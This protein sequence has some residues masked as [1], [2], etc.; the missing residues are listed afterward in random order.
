VNVGIVAPE[1]PPEI[2]GIQTY[3]YEFSV[4][5]ARRGINVTVFTSRANDISG[6]QQDLRIVPVL[7]CRRRIDAGVLA[8]Y[9]FD[10]WHS[11]NAAYSWLSG[12][13]DRVVLSVHGNDFLRPYLLMERPNLMRYP[14]FW[15][16]PALTRRVERT[17]GRFRTQRLVTRT[18]PRV[19]HIITNSMFT[20]E[21][22]LQKYPGCKG[23]TSPGMVGVGGRFLESRN[24]GIENESGGRNRLV[25][26]CRLE[27]ERK[28]V[29]KVLRALATLAPKW[30]F[31][32]TIVGDGPLRAYLEGIVRD[33]GLK[34]RVT[35]EG[36]V[37]DVQLVPILQDSD[38]FV[39]TSDT[40]AG[41]HEGFGIAYL[42][43]NA[44]GVPV[45]A[46]RIAGAQEAVSDGVSGFFVDN[47]EVPDIAAALES[48]FNSE[49]QFYPDNCRQFAAGFTWNKVVDHA[50]HEYERLLA[51]DA[52]VVNR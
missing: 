14:G 51:E 39:L 37:A 27:D 22:L 15:R 7:A 47:P 34:E 29:D 36:R 33:L 35:F 52:S 48:Y 6:L 25:T 12:Q 32:Y 43:A 18:L 20:E 10:I 1:F 50:L 4:E 24:S 38:L 49:R 2:G 31:A 30:E 19:R 26:V 23:L 13:F 44:C 28:N 45:L 41:S 46:A 42:E 11:M 16:V 5:L 9:K 8:H 40:R 3:A 17:I 21:V